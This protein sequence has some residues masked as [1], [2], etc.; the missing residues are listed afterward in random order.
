MED[1]EH[2]ILPAADQKSDR[3]GSPV[4][5]PRESD[6]N[7]RRDTVPTLPL[8]GNRDGTVACHLSQ[9]TFGRR[10]IHHAALG[11]PRNSAQRVGDSPS[12]RLR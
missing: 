3:A 6:C 9:P 7:V 5:L 1:G 2:D 4:M 11:G 12:A 10:L 8:F